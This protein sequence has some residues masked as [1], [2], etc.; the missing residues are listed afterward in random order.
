MRRTLSPWQGWF[1]W[2]SHVHFNQRGWQVIP[3]P[4]LSVA[5][6][7]LLC[8]LQI[9]GFCS[10]GQSKFT[11][12]LHHPHPLSLHGLA[13]HTAQLWHN[14]TAF[15]S[16]GHYNKVS[17]S[18]SFL[19]RK[20]NS[21]FWIP[22]CKTKPSQGKKNPNQQRETEDWKQQIFTLFFHPS[23]QKRTK[24]TSGFDQGP[25]AESSTF[26]GRKRQADKWF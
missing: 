18:T 11:F 19:D 24:I 7:P 2:C 9:W 26:E 3:A 25:V 1:P 5:K 20:V 22:I 17:S 8:L 12:F 16:H 10:I 23:Y 14:R 4:H 6:L 15:C 21:A 13:L